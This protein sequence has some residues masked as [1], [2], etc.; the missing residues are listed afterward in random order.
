M[1]ASSA[2]PDESEED[3]LWSH[4]S[5]MKDQSSRDALALHYARW[6]RQMAR[7]VFVLWQMPGTEWSDYVHYG[8]L[9]LLESIDRFDPARGA[10]FRTYARRR[11]KGAIINGIKAFGSA[12]SEAAGATIHERADSLVGSENQSPLEEL[13]TVSI[14]LAIGHFL[15]I[16]SVQARLL[17]YSDYYAQSEKED[18]QAMLIDCVA[19]LPDKERLIITFH[20]LQQLPFVEIAEH[21]KLSKGRISQLHKRAI[22]RLRQQFQET[23]TRDITV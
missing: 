1:A 10:R 21:L 6:V 9:G 17:E 7:Q 23:S 11:V 3:R 2:V 5:E 22:E 8:T 12:A 14:G 15:D 4:F 13:V 19:R 20:Y 16:E 18:I